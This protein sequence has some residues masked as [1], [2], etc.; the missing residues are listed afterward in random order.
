[1][2]RSERAE[3]KF[4]VKISF[5]LFNFARLSYS[6]VWQ[7]QEKPILYRV[8]VRGG[9]DPQELERVFMVFLKKDEKARF[10][11][12][13]REA[14]L[15]AAALISTPV[16]VSCKA[17]P[18][19][20]EEMEISRAPSKE[21]LLL[22]KGFLEA[23]NQVRTASGVPPLSWNQDLADYAQQWADELKYGNECA[24][25]HRPI[26]GFFAQ[27][28]GENIAWNQG[29]TSLPEV[30]VDQWV[31]E[32]A[33]YNAQNNSCAPQ[34]ICGHYTQVVWRDSTDLGCGMVS[35]PGETE[36]WVCNYKPY[37]N[38]KGEPPF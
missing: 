38:I 33:F 16:V 36:L 8:N 31:S 37:G 3:L 21:S 2:C 30:V 35:C 12:R 28:Y 15:A 14:V 26:S 27:K 11:R 17:E 34:Q 10:K 32:K 9:S 13:W 18:K 29:M 6:F 19:K 1:M 25:M 20:R 7:H 4:L 5:Y 24:P 22:A 23:H